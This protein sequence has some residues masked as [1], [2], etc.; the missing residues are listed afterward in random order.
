MLCMIL[1]ILL[2]WYRNFAS[3][4][5]WAI[6]LGGS[7]LNVPQASTVQKTITSE[8]ANC[9]HYYHT[10]WGDFALCYKHIGESLCMNGIVKRSK[11][12]FKWTKAVGLFWL[13]DP[14]HLWFLGILIRLFQ[15]LRILKAVWQLLGSNMALYWAW[16][17]LF[18]AQWASQHIIST[19]LSRSW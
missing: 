11:L 13:A 10:T 16:L 6:R 14:I 4:T 15:F 5:G 8:Y 18:T 1:G 9:D 12:S 2:I 19:D 17:Y 7:G 3:S